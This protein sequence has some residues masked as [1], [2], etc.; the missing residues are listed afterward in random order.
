MTFPDPKRTISELKELRSF[1]ADENGAQRI[2]FTPTWVQTR[3]WLREKLEQL[4]VEAHTDA[5]GNLWATLSGRSEKALL[6]GGHMDSV[7]N[8]GWLDRCLHVVAGLE[9]FRRINPQNAGR[10]PV[11]GRLGGLVDAG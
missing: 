7:P 3:A 4:P 11:T 6:I 10:P 1:T 9:I 8:R 2:A 5:A